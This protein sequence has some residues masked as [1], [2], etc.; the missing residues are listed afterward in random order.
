[1]SSPEGHDE[2]GWGWGA[3]GE[4]DT[5]EHQVQESVIPVG[6][7]SLIV[8]SASDRS[9]QNRKHSGVGLS[10]ITSSPSFQELEKAIGATLALNL[11]TNEESN[12]QKNLSPNSS[13]LTSKL[14]STN[15]TQQK[16]LQQRMR[17]F[18]ANQRN[19]NLYVRHSPGVI[20]TS[21][22]SAKSELSNFINEPEARALV[23]FHSP[24]ISPN[25]VKE[26]CSKFGILYYI[27]P[28]FHHHKGVTFISYFDLQAAMTCKENL[29]SVFPAEA[30]ISVYYSIMLHA[31]ASN[32]EEF[33]L[34]VKNS[35]SGEPE[36][37]VQSIFSRY[38]QL[39][40]IQKTFGSSADLASS[41]QSL[42]AVYSV[43]YFNIQDARLAASELSAT[44]AAILGSEASVSFAPLDERK[45]QLCR[46]LLATLSRWRSEIAL[47]TATGAIPPV[48]ASPTSLHPFLPAVMHM[49]P[50]AGLPFGQVSPGL[51]PMTN[52]GVDVNGYMSM[53]PGIQ[54]FFPPNAYSQPPRANLMPSGYF[55]FPQSFPQPKLDVSFP[56]YQIPFHENVSHVPPAARAETTRTTESDL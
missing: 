38:G 15:L 23:V 13:F 25:S 21:S 4:D 33:R 34:L 14:S 55:P 35:S 51:F 41:S 22:I 1:M 54:P 30:E 52:P 18:Q 31:T 5:S 11:A 12:E 7:K 39:R 8:K 36:A 2:E 47:S 56:P 53:M 19:P 40:S 29:S 27:R 26:A 24:S 50:N 17:Q 9:L 44:S 48:P 3:F 45:Q 32:T 43:E 28:E 6:E 49:V 42:P 20:V 46:Q 37:E 16:V 10:G